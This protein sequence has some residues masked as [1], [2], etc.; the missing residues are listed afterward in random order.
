[1]KI[2]TVGGLLFLAGCTTTTPQIEAVQVVGTPQAVAA[3]KYVRSV[4]GDQNM[5]GGVMFQGAAYND[6]INQ[7]KKQTIEA[8]G[9]RLY[10]VNATAGLGGANAVGD[11]YKC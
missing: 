9:N 8:G 2:R 7:M 4:R 10:I 6:A 1:M 5:I 3:C 11:A